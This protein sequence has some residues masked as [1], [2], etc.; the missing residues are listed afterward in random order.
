MKHEYVSKN[1][2]PEG[3]AKIAEC[4]RIIRKYQGMD[5]K[6]T[7]RQLY[8]QLVTQNTIANSERE[9]KRLGNLV[10]EARL[11]G[12]VDWAAIEDRGRVPHTPNEF[13]S[14]TSLIEAAIASYRLPRW[15]GQENYVE[16]WVEKDALSGVL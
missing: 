15:K 13:S 14:A 4:N 1:F 7:L 6:L 3:L 10:S 2:R 11:A 5:L 9:Y 8:Y 12:M 16:L